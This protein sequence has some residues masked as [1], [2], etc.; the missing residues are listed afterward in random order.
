[1]WAGPPPPSPAPFEFHLPRPSQPGASCSL[2][3]TPTLCPRPGPGLRSRRSRI[4]GRQGPIVPS[5]WDHSCAV[6]KHLERRIPGGQL[7]LEWHPPLLPARSCV[8]P[9]PLPAPLPDA[10]PSHL[11]LFVALHSNLRCTGCAPGNR[12]YLAE[13][14]GLMSAKC[15]KR[16][17]ELLTGSL[18]SKSKART[19]RPALPPFIS[20]IKVPQCEGEEKAQ[21]WLL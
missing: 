15:R 21:G 1:M 2:L 14:R 17:Q 5:L 11:S 10:P 6:N 12:M 4:P 19:V 7:Y 13:T 18:T 16:S 9:S 3:P 8:P 20:P